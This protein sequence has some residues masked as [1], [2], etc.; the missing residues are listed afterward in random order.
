MVN[1]N[2]SFFIREAD[3]E[4]IIEVRNCD[5]VIEFCKRIYLTITLKSEYAIGINY[6]SKNAKNDNLLFII[7][8]PYK[9]SQS[10]KINNIS[11]SLYMYLA[12]ISRLFL[13]ENIF[14][15]DKNNDYYIE[16][17]KI[18]QLKVNYMIHLVSYFI[19]R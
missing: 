9:E 13:E 3:K 8:E 14:V 2:F 6:N 1:K 10:I 19:N 12:R 18:Q 7:G 11:Y 16:C 15:A 4:E 17:F 5:E